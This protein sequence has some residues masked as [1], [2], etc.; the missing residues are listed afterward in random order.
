MFYVPKEQ[1]NQGTTLHPGPIH[2]DT[3]SLSSHTHKGRPYG[4]L[5][6]LS[7]VRTVF[8]TCCYYYYYYYYYYVVLHIKNGTSI[9]DVFCVR[10]RFKTVYFSLAFC[11]I[12]FDSLGQGRIL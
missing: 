7:Y 9:Y 11:P 6:C 5:T 3:R 10:L 2:S 12:N 1:I 4:R 8:I